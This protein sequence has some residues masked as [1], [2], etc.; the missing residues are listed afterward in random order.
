[1][2]NNLT[3]K[4]KEIVGKFRKTFY[5]HDEDGRELGLI[6]E[7]SGQAFEQFI[8]EAMRECYEEGKDAESKRA[9][10]YITKACML[11]IQYDAE[12]LKEP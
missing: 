1:M 12:G 3:P 5:A 2:N 9:N 8:I 6:G 7:I 4:M 11:F 10:Q